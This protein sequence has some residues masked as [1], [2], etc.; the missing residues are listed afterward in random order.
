MWN[1]SILTSP[2]TTVPI[3]LSA[4]DWECLE[5]S[6]ARKNSSDAQFAPIGNFAPLHQLGIEV[7]KN[8]NHKSNK[9]ILNTTPA[10][11]M[12]SSHGLP[13]EKDGFTTE[14][15]PP[16]AAP[17]G[18]TSLF[19]SAEKTLGRAPPTTDVPTTHLA[20]QWLSFHPSAWT[21]TP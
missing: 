1:I 11:S 21:A 2:S 6:S 17:S 18:T 8:T 4:G 15:R 19:A 12:D 16:L 9:F 10:C 3:P 5:P 14:R 20:H 7:V 13:K